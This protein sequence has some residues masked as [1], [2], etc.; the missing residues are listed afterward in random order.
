MEARTPDPDPCRGYTALNPGFCYQDKKHGDWE[1]R[2]LHNMYG[3]LYT[4]ATHQGQL[5]RADSTRRPFILTRSAFAG[6]QRYRCT[7]TANV[8]PD[9]ELLGPDLN[10]RARKPPKDMDPSWEKLPKQLF[11]LSVKKNLLSYRFS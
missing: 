9:P 8:P 2:D 10:L 1:H 11:S 7:G 3:M 4:M 6:S 5:V